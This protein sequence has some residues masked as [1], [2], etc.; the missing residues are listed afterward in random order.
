MFKKFI[1][2]EAISCQKSCLNTGVVIGMGVCGVR[3]WI[4]TVMLIIKLARYVSPEPE[5]VHYHIFKRPPSAPILSQ[6]NP[7]YTPEP[8]SLRSNLIPSSIYALVFQVVC[9]LQSCWYSI[10]AKISV[11]LDLAKGVLILFC[12]VLYHIKVTVCILWR[13]YG[14]AH[15]LLVFW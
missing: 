3:V 5:Q 9:F 1:T 15:C 12:C 2:P 11:V 6:L 7:L 10:R 13:I 14:C 4:G 8:L